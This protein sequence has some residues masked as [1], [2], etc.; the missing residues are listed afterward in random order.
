MEQAER[1]KAM[2]VIRRLCVFCGSSD[3]MHGDYLT[4]AEEMG[5]TA[6]AHG[7]EIVFGGG[8]TGMMGALADGALD[9]G[10]RVIGVIPELFNTPELLH[11]GLKDLHVVESMHARKAL[12]A[13]LADAFVALP[14]GFG[15][16]E[17]LF[18]MLTW[19]QIG[20]HTKPIGLLNVRSYF[21]PLIDLIKHA[22][23]QGFIYDEH[24]ELILVNEQ[25][26]E[27]ITRIESFSIPEGLERWVHR[28]ETS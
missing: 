28:R 14:G 19:M 18:E 22:Q 2:T 3:K 4:A 16:L 13:E 17:E 1:K 11:A 6:A 15:T 24:L 27:L 9:S 23:E 7:L 8:G 26:G 10:G 12:M 25:P 21:D 5:R 20:L